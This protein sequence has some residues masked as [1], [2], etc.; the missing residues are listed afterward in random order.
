MAWTISPW[1]CF[2]GQYW[3]D[4]NQGCSRD[5]FRVFCNFTAGGET[6]LFPEKKLEAVSGQLEY[7]KGEK[8]L[9]KLPLPKPTLSLA[10]SQVRLA[11][12]S[13]EKPGTWFSAFK[14]G[15]K[16][17]ARQGTRQPRAW[18][19]RGSHPTLPCSSPTWMR[20]GTPCP[21]PSSPSCGC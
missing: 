5:A 15:R 18:H 14:R 9:E 1:L 4:P 2:P 13:R 17:G 8:G 10:S 21:C 12:W 7:S 3:I 20:M 11:A 19:P 6:C 16:V